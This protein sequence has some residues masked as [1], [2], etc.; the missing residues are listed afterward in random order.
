MATSTI[1]QYGNVLVEGPIA[2]T[3][4]SQSVRDLITAGLSAG[5]L[6]G[7]LPAGGNNYGFDLTNNDGAAIAYLS[8]S[9]TPSSTRFFRQ[10]AANGSVQVN[11]GPGVLNKLKIAASANMNGYLVV[12]G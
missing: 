4:A 3:T 11:A 12:F 7:V 1:Q 2:I 6:T 5:T 9:G 10:I 8:F